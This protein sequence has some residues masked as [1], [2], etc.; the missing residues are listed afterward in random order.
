MVDRTAE[1][2]FR[3]LAPGAADPQAALDAVETYR[4]DPE[5]TSEGILE[6]TRPER[7]VYHRIT[8]PVRN[9]DGAL[10]GR[11]WTFRDITDRYRARPDGVRPAAGQDHPRLPRDL[12][13]PSRTGGDRPRG[14]RLPGL[15]RGPPRRG[16]AADRRARDPDVR[17]RGPVRAPGAGNPPVRLIPSRH[18]GPAAPRGAVSPGE[19]GAVPAPHGERAGPHLPVSGHGASRVRV[20]Q[21]C[22]DADDRVHARGALR[23]PPARLQDR[24]PGRPPDPRP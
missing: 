4:A 15:D 23:A 7:R 20:R 16:R 3:G 24:P 13:G 8:S 2:L 5:A 11:L 1:D 21:P 12:P 22:R 17:T 6:I 18:G 19:R 9:P 14:P 10:I